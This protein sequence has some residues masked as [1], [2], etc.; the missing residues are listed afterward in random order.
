MRDGNEF[1]ENRNRLGEL[2]KYRILNTPPEKKFDDL[3]K[4]MAMTCDV[5]IALITFMDDKNQY[6]KSRYGIDFTENPIEN[7]FC[8]HILKTPNKVTEISNLRKDNSVSQNPFIV[9]NPKLSFYAGYPLINA[10]GY[11]LGS[12]CLYGFQVKKLSNTQKDALKIIAQQIIELLELRK[13]QLFIDEAKNKRL[14][15]NVNLKKG[16]DAIGLATW[17]WNITT[18]VCQ[19]SNGWAELLGY[20]LSELEPTNFQTWVDLVHPDDISIASDNYYNALIKHDNILDV[21]FRMRKKD[22]KYLWIQSKGKTIKKDT[23]GKPIIAFGIHIDINDKKLAEKQLKRINENIPAAVFRYVAYSNGTSKLLYYT[24]KLNQLYDLPEDL[25]LDGDNIK[26]VWNKIHPDDLTKVQAAVEKSKRELSEYKAD[27]RIINDNGKTKWLSASGSIFFSNDEETVWDTAVFDVTEEKLASIKLEEINNQLKKAQKIGKLGYWKHNLDQDSLTWSTEIYNL[28]ELDENKT[29]PSFELFY[30]MLHPEDKQQFYE[31]STKAQVEN[32][33]ALIEHRILLPDDRIKWFELTTGIED[34]NLKNEKIREW[35]VQDIT[36]QKLLSISVEES[37]NRFRLATQATADIIWDWDIKENRILFGENFSKFIKN[38]FEDDQIKSDYFIRKCIHANDRS[39]VRKSLMNALNN[40]EDYWKCKYRVKSNQ[41]DY[42]YIQDNALII[43]DKKGKALRMVGAMNEITEQKEQTKKL[44]Q[45]NKILKIKSLDLIRS[46]DDL[47]QFAYVASH[48]LQEPL[49]MITSFLT[50]LE[51]RY[52]DKLDDKAKT[53]IHFAVDGAKRMRTIILDLLDYSRVGKTESKLTNVDVNE[54]V[55]DVINFNHRTI[56]KLNATIKVEE[57]PIINSYNSE[58]THVFSNILGNALKYQVP[59]IKPEIIISCSD[60]KT[61]WE[62]SIEDNGIGID[63]KYT[64][65]VFV[66][67][68]RLHSKE[69]YSGT[70]IGLAI[71]KKIINTL[72]G[73]IWIEKAK[74]Q[75]SIF[76]FT[77]KKQ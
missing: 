2:I 56:S 75:G 67:F 14:L 24:K 7:S 76:K 30:N 51:K 21:E 74:K 9:N 65:Q 58:L 46:N 1:F 52:E 18:N 73:E 23:N 37:N 20:K 12:I 60:I 26:L 42:L 55:N 35:V 34:F 77:I 5:P 71:S 53:Y 41:G 28:L 11:L 49:R 63:E 72:G 48:D 16:I 64:D 17:E 44:R 50:L 39:R 61:H 10:D 27:Y 40:E 59:N 4:L 6:F 38:D 33:V 15:D 45:L 47:E 31:E 68:K 25:S 69:E 43:R 32:K 36:E 29:T 13:S 19:F 62:F 54:L 22:G 8:N 3:A 70:G 57:L 66:I